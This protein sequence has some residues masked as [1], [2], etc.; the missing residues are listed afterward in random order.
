M[1]SKVGDQLSLTWPRQENWQET[2]D[3]LIGGDVSSTTMRAELPEPTRPAPVLED[4]DER[5]EEVREGPDMRSIILSTPS[6]APEARARRVSLPRMPVTLPP[7]FTRRRIRPSGTRKRNEK[8]KPNGWEKR[9]RYP[10]HIVSV[11]SFQTILTLP[12]R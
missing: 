6:V 12:Y 5:I 7:K 8:N 9:I 10:R 11:S 3:G 4:G 1:K 2:F